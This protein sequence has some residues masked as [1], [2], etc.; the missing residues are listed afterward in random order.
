MVDSTIREEG[1]LIVED[2]GRSDQYHIAVRLF[3]REGR[4]SRDSVLFPLSRRVYPT[5]FVGGDIVREGG[6]ECR[7]DGEEFAA[8]YVRYVTRF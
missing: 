2:V 5:P 3:F 8:V 1:D 7:C 6:Q 4:I